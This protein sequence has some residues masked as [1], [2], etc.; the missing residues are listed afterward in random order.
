MNRPIMRDCGLLGTSAPFVAEIDKLP[1]VGG[2][3]VTVLISGETGTGKE[4]IARAIHY[5]SARSAWPFVPVD[6]GAIPTELAESELFGHE[7]GA[8][9]GALTKTGGLVESAKQGTLFLDEVEVLPLS[10]Q[11][12]LLRFLQQREY[13]ALGSSEVRRA[14]VRVISATN[15]DLQKL[16][17]TGAFREDLYYRLKVVELR[18]PALRDRPED[19]APL[20]KH[21]VAKYAARFNRQTLD[22]SPGALA[23]LVSHRWPGNVRELEH[24]LEAAVALC[25]GAQIEAEDLGLE[26]AGP[27]RTMS[28]REAKARAVEAF[29]RKFIQQLLQAHDGNIAEASRAAKKNRR[30]FWEL[31]RKHGISAGAHAPHRTGEPVAVASTTARG[32]RHG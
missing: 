31:M 20:A 8:F 17:R 6:C 11:A 2:C 29:E 25:A 13:R 14:D 1:S 9:T 16:V 5:L 32:T 19:I 3:D 28:F 27:S 21:F 7:R 10:V 4:L 24:V 23:R 26:S 15:Y 22:L 12:K 18:M 30:A